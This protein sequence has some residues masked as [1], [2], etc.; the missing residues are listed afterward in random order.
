MVWFA[1]GG[2]DDRSSLAGVYIAMR[3]RMALWEN[4]LKDA[5]SA[6]EDTK[7]REQLTWILEDIEIYRT[8]EKDGLGRLRQIV[9]T[10][11]AYAGKIS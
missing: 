11:R 10:L 3:E 9:E 4:K 2:G 7:A 5:R 1:S 6:S 8:S